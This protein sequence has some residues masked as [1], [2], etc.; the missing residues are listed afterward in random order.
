METQPKATFA[1]LNPVACEVFGGRYDPARLQLGHRL[2]AGVAGEPPSRDTGHGHPRLGGDPGVGPGRWHRHSS[3]PWIRSENE[4]CDKGIS[5]DIWQ[6]GSVH[7]SVSEIH[8][9]TTSES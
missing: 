7:K 9:L 6:P 1:W 5:L 2:I 3:V 4:K 8:K